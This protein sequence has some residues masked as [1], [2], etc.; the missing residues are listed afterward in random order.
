MHL[1][2]CTRC[3]ARAGFLL[4]IPSVSHHWINARSRGRWLKPRA[5]VVCMSSLPGH[6]DFIDVGSVFPQYSFQQKFTR[7]GLNEPNKCLSPKHTGDT[8]K[9]SIKLNHKLDFQGLVFPPKTLKQAKL[10]GHRFKKS[11]KEGPWPETT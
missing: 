8:H 1:V 3:S 10:S 6:V 2:I 9:S 5:D 4:F 11:S 7:T